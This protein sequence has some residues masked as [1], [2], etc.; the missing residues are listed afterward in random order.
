MH[1]TILYGL[2]FN[3][4]FYPILVPQ[5]EQVTHLDLLTPLPYAYLNPV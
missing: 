2:S 4:V 1:Y 5:E 3:P